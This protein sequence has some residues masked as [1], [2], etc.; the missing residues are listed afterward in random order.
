MGVGC[1]ERTSA[2]VDWQAADQP[3]WWYTQ[4][5]TQIRIRPDSRCAAIAEPHPSP[6]SIQRTPPVSTLVPWKARPGT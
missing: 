6:C 3:V 2:R 5:S 1:V 4:R